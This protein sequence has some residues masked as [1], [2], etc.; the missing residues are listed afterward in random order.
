MLIYYKHESSAAKI[1][2]LCIRCHY[3]L[4]NTVSLHRVKY[5]H[6]RYKKKVSNKTD[7][8]LDRQTRFCRYMFVRCFI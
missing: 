8:A 3:V 1:I 2:T 5:T 7:E 4:I 6:T